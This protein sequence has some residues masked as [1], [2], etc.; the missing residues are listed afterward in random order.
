MLFVVS[1]A[2]RPSVGQ[3]RSDLLAP[4]EKSQFARV[5]SHQDLLNYLDVL[6][7]HSPLIT[8]EVVGSTTHGRPIPLVKVSSSTFGS[9]RAKLRVFLFSSQHGNEPS[10]K[11]ALLILLK[12]IALG[13]R[14]DWLKTIDLLIAPSVNPDGNEAGR[15][16]NG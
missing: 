11:E 8:T 14:T 9:D 1:G 3:S 4:I 13:E 6:R 12:S 16:Q 7:N 10:G 5:S 2:M 15:R